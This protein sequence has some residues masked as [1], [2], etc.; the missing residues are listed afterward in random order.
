MVSIISQHFSLSTSISASFKDVHFK[1]R[2]RNNEE[3]QMLML[4]SIQNCSFKIHLKKRRTLVFLLK[5]A[6]SKESP[7]FLALNSYH[8]LVKY[9][10]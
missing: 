9:N 2:N 1:E 3:T 8:W 6:I 7:T 5:S 10:H 4:Q